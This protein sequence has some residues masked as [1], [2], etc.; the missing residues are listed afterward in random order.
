MKHRLILFKTLTVVKC[1]G[2]NGE[3]NRNIENFKTITL[4]EIFWSYVFNPLILKI[5][6]V[7]ILP[8]QQ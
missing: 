8:W 2:E 5:T 7:C 3:I 4:W 1:Y 6:G